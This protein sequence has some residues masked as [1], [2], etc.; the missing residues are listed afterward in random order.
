[1][2]GK[3]GTVLALAAARLIQEVGFDPGGREPPCG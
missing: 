3:L 1:M 2:G